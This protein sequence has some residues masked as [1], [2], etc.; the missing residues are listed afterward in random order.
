MDLPTHS[1]GTHSLTHPASAPTVASEMSIG[2]AHRPV[3]GVTTEAPQC[4]V[5]VSSDGAHIVSS[6]GNGEIVL[7]A[8]DGAADP[9]DPLAAG[10]AKLAA[11]CASA[12]APLPPETSAHHGQVAV[13]EVSEDVIEPTSG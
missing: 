11:A 8:W 3:L 5:G 2:L 1:H 6:G 10:L 7:W 4:F 9:R 12:A 13:T